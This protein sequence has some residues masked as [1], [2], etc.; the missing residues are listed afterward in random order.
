MAVP[1][2]PPDK[3]TWRKLMRPALQVVRSLERNGYGMLDYSLGGGTVLMLRFDHRVSKDIDIFTYDAQAIGFI[4]PRLN[5]VAERLAVEYEEQSNFVKL[6]LRDG[7]IDFIV[8]G[9][10]IPDAPLEAMVVDGAEVPLEA[11]SE[12][13]A[14]KLLYRADGF[15]A[16]DVFDMSAALDLDPSSAAAAMEAA[17]STRPVLLRRLAVMAA[18]PEEELIAG[19]VLTPGGRRHVSGMVEKLRLAIAEAERHGEGRP[20]Q[21]LRRR[22]ALRRRAGPRA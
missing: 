19:I 17:W 1:P 14:K 16:R 12:I 9:P 6:Q 21:P 20:S 7:D 18:A 11:T 5:D 4:T 22:A 10:V 8:A 3:D 13:L 2:S 15:K